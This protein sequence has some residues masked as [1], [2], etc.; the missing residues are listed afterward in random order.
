MIDDFKNG[1]RLD[2]N[3]D[4]Y[5]AALR[6]HQDGLV[7]SLLKQAEA[8]FTLHTADCKAICFDLKEN[9]CKRRSGKLLFRNREE[10][11]ELAAAH[12]VNVSD[13]NDCKQCIKSGA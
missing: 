4:A 10:L 7:I 1:V 2:G 11:F 3:E 9:R 8:K 6:D 5:Q 13:L 12:G